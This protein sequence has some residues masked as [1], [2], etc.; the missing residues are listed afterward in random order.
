VATCAT[1]G[2]RASLRHPFASRTEERPVG[3]GTASSPLPR[4]TGC[5]I[6][7]ASVPT[8]TPHETMA[9]ESPTPSA[10][11]GLTSNTTDPRQDLWVSAYPPEFCVRVSSTVLT[12]DTDDK[13]A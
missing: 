1:W 2:P 9:T 6:R 12:A 5:R 11:N 3:P 8:N 4:P 10:H 13:G 7:R